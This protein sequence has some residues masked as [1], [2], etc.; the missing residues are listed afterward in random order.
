MATAKGS[1]PSVQFPCDLKTWPKVKA[2]LLEIRGSVQIND[3]V[4]SLDIIVASLVNGMTSP[5]KENMILRK[6]VFYGLKRFLEKDSQPEEKDKFYLETFPFIIDC[7]LRI[8]DLKPAV[9]L[10]YSLQKEGG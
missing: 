7:A 10:N 8:E 4:K 5:A 6:C 9:G 2:A 3:I 1:P